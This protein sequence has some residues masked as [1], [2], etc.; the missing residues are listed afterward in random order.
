MATG[1]YWIMFRI[2]HVCIY[3]LINV[4][5]QVKMRLEY[6][7]TGKGLQTVPQSY[8]MDVPSACTIVIIA[9]EIKIS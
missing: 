9:G 3:E 6:G 5:K 8:G 2:S 4:N 7:L 1:L